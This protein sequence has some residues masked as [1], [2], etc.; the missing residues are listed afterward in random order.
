MLSFNEPLSLAFY[1]REDVL[2]VARELLGMR[3]MVMQAD[4]SLRSGRIVETEAYAGVTDRA[5]HA[6][7]HRRT[8]RTETMYRAGGAAYVYLCYGI[9]HLLNVV[10][11]QADVP[12]A[13]LIRGVAM[14]PELGLPPNAGAGPGK[15]TKALGVSTRTHN[16]LSLLGPELWIAEADPPKPDLIL[17]SPR[18]GVDYAGD[19][20]WLP[21]RFYLAAEAGVSKYRAPSV[22]KPSWAE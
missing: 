22:P 13:V 17:T 14:D 3:L 1:Q 2:A 8:A 20:A 4:G 21:Y 9:H 6:Y 5:S 15:L 18:V 7:G 12:Y 19:D 16:G 11:H 10:T